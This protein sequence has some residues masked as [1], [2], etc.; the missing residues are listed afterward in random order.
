MYAAQGPH[1]YIYIYIYI[2]WSLDKEERFPRNTA[3]LTKNKNKQYP[4]ILNASIWTV[5]FFHLDLCRVN[6]S[7]IRKDKN[8]F[9]YI[10][11]RTKLLYLKNSRFKAIYIYIG[12]IS[13]LIQISLN[14]IDIFCLHIF[15]WIR[16]FCRVAF[17]VFGRNWFMYCP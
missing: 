3:T 1:I 2:L 15:F 11:S 5:Y 13:S 9:A 12:S 10:Q 14:I 16:S 17:I 7:L 6:L 4:Y 8:S